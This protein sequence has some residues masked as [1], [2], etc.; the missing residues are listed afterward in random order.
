MIK[1]RHNQSVGSIHAQLFPGS[2]NFCQTNS[3]TKMGEKTILK[4]P[5][6][7]FVWDKYSKFFNSL[8]GLRRPEPKKKGC[9]IP[10]PNEIKLQSDQS[11][12]LQA[13]H[14]PYTFQH[15]LS[16][17]EL[18]GRA[19]NTFGL[20][21]FMLLALNQQRHRHNHQRC[22]NGVFSFQIDGKGF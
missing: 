15:V 9:K 3:T 19:K 7:N 20:S 4:V 17:S 12:D 22:K 10:P 16:V 14:I 1:W 11:P 21:G 8:T 18:S 6:G 2:E 5:C 13:S